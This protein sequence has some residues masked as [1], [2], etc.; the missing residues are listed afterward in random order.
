M[1]QVRKK[2]AGTPG[3][4]GEFAGT[5]YAEA[6]VESLREYV[7]S[8]NVDVLVAAASQASRAR[9]AAGKRSWGE[10]IPASAIWRDETTTWDQKRDKFVAAVKA[11]T[12]YQAQDVFSDLHDAI[13][14]LEDAPD[15]VEM[16]YI[17]DGIYDQ[18]SVD[19]VNL[20]YGH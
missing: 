1:A 10:R 11:S 19:R 6:T 12:W 20:S 17:L 9:V 3:N 15:E 4:G 7:P 14:E 2:D 18:A 5:K 13:D 16:K 8:K